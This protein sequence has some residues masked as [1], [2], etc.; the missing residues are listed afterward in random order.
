MY[1]LNLTKYKETV[2]F[3]TFTKKSLIGNFIFVCNGWNNLSLLIYFQ[4][5]YYLIYRVDDVNIMILISNFNV[6]CCVFNKLTS[7]F[8]AHYQLFHV[9]HYFFIG[10]VYFLTG[11]FSFKIFKL[12]KNL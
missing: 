4:Y 12:K 9:F 3:V 7:Y 5:H 6:F 2:D 10:L 8:I 11:F 1:S